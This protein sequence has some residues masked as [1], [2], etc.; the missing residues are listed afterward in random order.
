MG[1]AEL[2]TN[3]GK[4]RKESVFFAHPMTFTNRN[5]KFKIERGLRKGKQRTQSLGEAEGGSCGS[6]FRNVKEDDGLDYECDTGISAYANK[7]RFV[8]VDTTGDG[9]VDSFEKVVT[10]AL[11]NMAST[12]IVVH[13]ALRWKRLALRQKARI[14]P[15]PLHSLA[16]QNAADSPKAATDIVIQEHEQTVECAEAARSNWKE[17]SIKPPRAGPATFTLRRPARLDTSHGE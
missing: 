12:A 1:T 11:R 3:D 15:Q 5:G 10:T 7:H 6:S 2:L 16:M 13:G 4:W 9:K 17:E 8:A 14:L